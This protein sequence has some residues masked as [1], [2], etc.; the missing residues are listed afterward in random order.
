[1]KKGRQ[2][3][4]ASALAALLV[5]AGPATVDELT[6]DPAVYTVLGTTFIEETELVLDYYEMVLDG[7]IISDELPDV[8]LVARR[9]VR[10]TDE[11]QAKEDGRITKLQRLF[12]DL[13]STVRV[14]LDVEGASEDHEA[15]SASDL[16]GSVV[17]FTWDDEEEEYTASFEEGDTGE[18]EHLAGM[19]MDADLSVFLPRGSVSAGDEWNVKTDGLEKVFAPG[20]DLWILPES[21]GSDP[22][23][24]LDAIAMVAA[25]MISLADAVDEFDGTVTAKY[26]GEREKGGQRL[27][28]VKLQFDLT[29]ESERGERLVVQ[30][31]DLPR[32]LELVFDELNFMFA[33]KGEADLLWDLDGNHFH[34][35]EFEG[36]VG[37][38]LELSWIQPMFE[39]EIEVLGNYELSG[40]T[41]FRASIDDA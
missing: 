11:V 8:R 21:L 7:S 28:V 33:I 41:R 3:L 6:L 37:L 5:G 36:D 24:N 40:T 20:G 10:F 15:V 4:L 32:E 38:V 19:V 26:L 2:T 13:G 29:S 39:S 31:R 25:T 23:L 12:E 27:G 17:L 18:E 34:S 14:S 30:A 1:M 9:E 16:Q 22:F 35:F